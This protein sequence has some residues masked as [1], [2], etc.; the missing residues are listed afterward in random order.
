MKQI[1][2]GV[3][4]ATLW[5]SAS[6]ATKIGLRSAEPLM[7]TNV[8]FLIAGALMLAWA[9]GLRRHRF[10]KRAEWLPLVFYG[11]LN[12]AIYLGAFAIA[13][14][15]VTAG[16]GTLAVGLNPLVISVLSAVWLKKRIAPVVWMGLCLGLAGVGVATFPALLNSTAT[17]KGIAILSLSML[18]YSIGTIY[19]AGRDWNLPRLAINGWQ[20]TAAA[21]LLLPLT[22]AATRWDHNH[23]DGQFWGA[24]GW[25]VLP[26]SV[27]AV[28]LWLYLLKLDPVRASLWLFLCPVLG[29][30]YAWLFLNEPI[31][32]HALAGTALVIL[33]LYLGQR[34]PRRHP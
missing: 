27:G 6:V 7:I 21:L 13:M 32:P 14:Q 8:R 16:V 18:S 1:L 2:A 34:P 5:A 31:T 3:L 11:A 26:V 9:H 25:L 4:F 22:G 30:F 10:P 23:F 17:P 28:Q 12:G 20:I 24:V 33:G 29:F 15:E 19:F